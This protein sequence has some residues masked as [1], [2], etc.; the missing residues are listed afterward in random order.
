MILA[1]FVLALDALRYLA[2]PSEA[3]NTVSYMKRQMSGE[4]PHSGLTLE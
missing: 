4:T 3:I 2:F 1:L